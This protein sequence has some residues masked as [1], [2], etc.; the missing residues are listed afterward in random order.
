MLTHIEWCER[1][2]CPRYRCRACIENRHAPDPV[3][4]E[5][6]KLLDREYLGRGFDGLVQGVEALIALLE[7]RRS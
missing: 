1:A 6:A 5:A 4:I 3:A 2:G 7:E